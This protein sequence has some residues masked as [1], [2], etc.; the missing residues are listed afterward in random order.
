MSTTSGACVRR[1]RFAA[2]EGMPM[3]TKQTVPSLSRRAASMVMISVEVYSSC[4]AVSGI[5]H[6][7]L[8]R[9]DAG[10]LHEFRMRRRA[11]HMLRHPLRERLAILGDAVPGLAEGVVAAIV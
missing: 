2:A 7:L 6:L 11:D 8:R 3:P 5:H 4:W 9:G 10:R 1:A